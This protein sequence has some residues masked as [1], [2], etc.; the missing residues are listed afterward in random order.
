ME[1]ARKPAKLTAGVGI[2]TMLFG[3]MLV[4]APS[5]G[6]VL[7]EGT[8]VIEGGGNVPICHASNS[9]TN[10]YIMNSPSYSA[11]G[12]VNGVNHEGHDGPVFE[13]GMKAD[14][15]EWGDIIPPISLDGTTL[16]YDGKNWTDEARQLY[17]VCIGQIFGATVVKTNNAN[18]EGDY[19]DDETAPAAGAD[20]PF[21]VVITNTGTAGLT[22]TALT[23]SWGQE[24]PLD[25]LDLDEG[26]LVCTTPDGD[27][28]GS[29][30]DGFTMEADAVI[31]ADAVV[32]CLF[33]VE[34]YSPAAG[35]SVTNTVTLDTIEADD[36][37]D[38]SIVRTPAENLTYTATVVKTNNANATGDY[39]D[40]ETAPAAAADVPFKVVITNTGSGD[41]TVDSLTDTWAGQSEALDLFGLG[42]GLQCTTP[43]GDDDGDDPDVFP[44]AVD[45]T[46][47]AGAVITCSFTVEDY[48]PA[49]GGSITN[50]VTLATEEAN[51]AA[52]TSVVRTPA[53]CQVNCGPIPDPD[54]DPEPELGSL[55]ITKVVAGEDAPE[56]WSFS[57]D[58]GN[59]STFDLSDERDSIPFT[60]LPEGDYTITELSAGAADLTSIVCTDGSAGT[61]ADDSDG[62]SVTVAL[63]EGEAVE[64]TFT[65][66]FPEV[67][68][69]EEEPE[70][71]PQPEPE[72]S[73][74]PQADQVRGEQVAR[75]PRTGNESGRLAVF[76]LTL[77]L[78]GA[79][80]VGGSRLRLRHLD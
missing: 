47:P 2:L 52:D 15:I 35:E 69:A 5:A 65:N 67:L 37:S 41:L 71:E 29:E 62:G 78:L 63:A 51:D 10:P 70:P 26:G 58:G 8:V 39:G 36:V 73:P 43:D 80:L 66:S 17:A 19:G 64:C 25:L 31:P 9:E 44:M 74:A 79:T 30:P 57:F 75:L 33:T 56:S 48:A 60:D 59:L 6:A 61:I 16:H 23:D 68:P 42:Q 77:L 38:T 46:I 76:G 22:V 54:P 13:P 28:D 32:T 27:D 55:T 45:A 7:P 21:K 11:T 40:D 14:K 49:A 20:V 12:D 18:G 34:D 1:H 72:P 53:G 4:I 24:Q 3:A 50:T